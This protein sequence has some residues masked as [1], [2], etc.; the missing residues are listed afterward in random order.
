[1]YHLRID[2]IDDNLTWEEHVENKKDEGHQYTT[3]ATKTGY[4]ALF[5]SPLNYGTPSGEDH[6]LRI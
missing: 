5:E 4:H 6:Q 3:E 1:M 2:I